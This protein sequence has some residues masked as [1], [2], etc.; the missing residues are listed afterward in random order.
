MGLKLKTGEVAE[1][2]D[3]SRRT[4][5]NWKN[6]GCPCSTS[7]RGKEDVFD[8]AEVSRW[9]VA[10]AIGD[11]NSRDP[12]LK[13][14]RLEILKSEAKLRDLRFRQREGQLIETNA[15][16]NAMANGFC[17]VKASFAG[18]VPWLASQ[19]MSLDRKS[20]MRGLCVA[21]D[22]RVDIAI[23]NAYL[24]VVR[25]LAELANR[26]GAKAEKLAA[27]KWKAAFPADWQAECERIIAAEMKVDDVKTDASSG[28]GKETKK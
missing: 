4:V 27:E 21:I 17:G 8:S 26:T 3:V 6:A 18:I 7:G 5:G 19:L 16:E 28:R 10:E 23:F 11:G 12:E 15:A 14:V 13:A 1:A 2:F 20:G 9:L 25:V 24:A 22:E